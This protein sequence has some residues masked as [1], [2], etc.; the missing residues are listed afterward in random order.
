MANLTVYENYTGKFVQTT[1]PP[2][3]T[4]VVAFLAALNIVLSITASLG[5]I[6]ILIVLPKVTSLHL[7]TK[8]LFRCLAVT[9]LCVGLISQ[10]L[11]ATF[12]I[13][14]ITTMDLSI[15]N[16]I[17]NINPVISLVL[18]GVSVVTSTAIS[19]DRLLALTLGLR[20]RHIVTLRRVRA[21]VIC[22]LFLSVSCGLIHFWNF[23]IT[24]IVAFIFAILCLVTSIFSYTKI[25]LKLRQH[26]VHVQEQV[27]QELPNGGGI[28]FD[29]ARYKRTV[30]SISW[31]QVALVVCYVPFCMVSIFR[32][33][34]KTYD[35]SWLATT[36]LV[37]LNSSLNPIL[38]C[39]KIK[40][41]RQAV[42]DTIS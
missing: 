18:C 6:L 20:Y 12:L 29:I 11:H 3:P 36:T 41:V 32:I 15:I 17:G 40:E 9:D 19:V 14:Y 25:R 26:Q 10:P 24:W 23:R 37:Y 33:N 42:K 8:L 34:D 39:W 38:Y 35:M 21:F 16:H 22:S 13:S 1:S 30:S 2:W 31:V 5:N 4:G 7:P 27:H 28:P